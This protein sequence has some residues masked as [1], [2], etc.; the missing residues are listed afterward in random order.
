V[1]GRDA[2]L[3]LGL[4]TKLL[5]LSADQVADLRGAIRTRQG[6]PADMDD[7]AKATGFDLDVVKTGIAILLQAG[8]LS[9]VSVS[10]IPENSGIPEIPENSGRFL[11]K[12]NK[13]K[14]SKRS[15]PS[16]APR[17]DDPLETLPQ[18]EIFYPSLWVFIV[19]AHPT[20]KIPDA[21]TKADYEAR[22]TLARL[23]RLDG[24]TECD[25]IAALE[26]LFTAEHKDAVFW[27]G[28]VG[29]IEPLR[30]RGRSGLMKMAAIHECWKKAT[31]TR[32]DTGEGW[33]DEKAAQFERELA[34]EGG[35]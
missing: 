18:L 34:R 30:K 11:T 13:I 9:D 27:R 6:A 35:A 29:A 33:T 14:G 2:A 20:A 12:G 21:G 8:W 32:Q 22:R 15:A 24:F 5:E 1:G 25:V 26:W 19:E 17:L 16:G 31:G 7:I 3:A 10:E 4:Y 23:V 28:Q